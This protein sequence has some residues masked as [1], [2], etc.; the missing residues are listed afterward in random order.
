MQ[1]VD[2][3]AQQKQD[4]LRKLLSTCGNIAKACRAAKVSRSAI[5][6]HREKNAD[7]GKA[8]DEVLDEVA[9]AA[10]QELYR[11]GVKGVLEPVWYK[12][13]KVGNIRKFSDRCLEAYLRAHRPDKYRERIDINNRHSG[14]LN[15]NI[16]AEIDRL[17]GEPG[18]NGELADG[19]SPIDK[20]GFGGIP[21]S[22]VP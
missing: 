20:P 2:L 14:Q 8:W 12:G 13:A 3:T 21:G 1:G 16:E 7:F 10:E 5:Y 4:F 18:S 6:E 9:D 15:V 17:Y 19:P 11:R 22:D